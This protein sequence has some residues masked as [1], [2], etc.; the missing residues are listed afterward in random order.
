MSLLTGTKVTGRD[1]VIATGWDVDDLG[2]RAAGELSPGV[3]S[4]F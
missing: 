4:R 3:Q 2:R 1:S